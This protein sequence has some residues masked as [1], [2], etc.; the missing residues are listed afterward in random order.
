MNEVELKIV[1]GPDKPDLQ[2][3]VA[4]PDRGLHIHF[5]TH[6]D[7][8]DARIERIE[9]LGDGTMFGLQ[10]HLISGL[11]KGGPFNGVYELDSRSGLIKAREPS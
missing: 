4:Y 7:A 2:W 5:R 10:G 9:E 1:D 6:D 3:A 11:Y 8:V